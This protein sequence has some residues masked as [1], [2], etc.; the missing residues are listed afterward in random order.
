MARVLTVIR[1]ALTVLVVRLAVLSGVLPILLTLSMG[2]PLGRSLLAAR[3]VW[4]GAG[5]AG[6]Q[7][8]NTCWR[9]SSCIWSQVNA[10]AVTGVVA[11]AVM[12]GAV[13]P[14]V[15]S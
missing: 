11:R 10:S 14:G 13:A 9:T 3:L 8:R 5:A 6:V 7:S 1:V 4:V 2:V 15:S 12:V